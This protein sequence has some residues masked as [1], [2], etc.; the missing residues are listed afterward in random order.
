MEK[1]TQNK[2]VAVVTGAASGI[3]KATAQA[4][5]NKG[6]KVALM[7]R[8]AKGLEAV[9]ASLNSED[10][11]AY[12]VDIVSE[13][14]VKK[15]I[16]DIKGHFGRID[17]LINSA[18]ITGETNKKSHETNL[19]NIRQ[20]MDVNFFGSYLSSK[21][22]LPIMLEQ[23]Y[24]RVL[25][26]ASIAGKEGNAGM[27]GY[28]ASKAA[29]I[30]MAK[31]QGKEYAEKGITV[32]ALAPS[33]IQ[34]PLVDALPQAQIDYMLEKVPAKRLCTL[35]EV[36]DMILF[37]TSPENSFATGFCFDLSGGRATY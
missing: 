33:V 27:L 18:G 21:Y 6:V 28:S 15:A 12:V 10:S 2:Q 8:D 13:E 17:I 23:G 11:K 14:E 19:E 29:V 16:E 4:L 36:A 9:L 22:V 26:V 1:T 7:D 5:A 34:T 32:N 37:I 25:H 31:V 30:G 24:G 35:K 20:I 3:G